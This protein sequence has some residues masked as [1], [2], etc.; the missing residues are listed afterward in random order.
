MIDIICP[1]DGT[2]HYADESNVGKTLRCR[3]CGA[4]LNIESQDQHPPIGIEQEPVEERAEAR[5]TSEPRGEPKTEGARPQRMTRRVDLLIGAGLG[6]TVVMLLIAFWP[7]DPPSV[8]SQ[9]QSSGHNPAVRET[10]PEPSSGISAPALVKRTPNVKPVQAKPVLERNPLGVLPPCAQ[11]REPLRL[12]TGDRIEP[13]GG[14]SGASNI[15]VMNA[16]GLDAAVKLVDSVTGRTS[17]FV[18]VQAGHSF[19]IEGIETG[20]YLLQ[21]QYGR[22]WIP[23]C[24]EFMRDSDYREFAAPF[25]FLDDR[26]RFY[27]VTLSPVVGGKTITRK[28]DRKR[29]LEGEPPRSDNVRN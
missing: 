15:R 25:V 22:D 12:K 10:S 9:I 21:F 23:E 28:I 4:T 5:V 11:G 8:S 18:Y 14:T 19:A 6:A 7:N 1:A 3:T 13:D 2:L 17:R 20:A 27:E 16:G 24:H 29:F 26:L